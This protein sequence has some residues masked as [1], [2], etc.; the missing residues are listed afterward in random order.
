[1]KHFLIFF[2]ALF[3]IC[4]QA[5]RADASFETAIAPL[6]EEYN[7]SEDNFSIGYYNTLTGETFLYNGDEPMIAGSIYKLP[8][9]LTY[10]EMLD[11]GEIS[12]DDL[13]SGLTI[14]MAMQYVLE[15]SNNELAQSLQKNIGGSSVTRPQAAKYYGLEDGEELPDIYLTENAICARYALNMMTYIYENSDVYDICLSHLKNAQPDKYA[16]EYI[17]D[18]EI[19]Q[20]YGYFEGYFNDVAIVYTDSPFIMTV[21]TNNVSVLCLPELY[22]AA[23]EYSVSAN[24]VYNFNQYLIEIINFSRIL[25]LMVI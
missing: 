19:A 1:M 3:C 13:V 16:H 25:S 14:D 23:Y 18:C 12:G 5:V 21:F 17:T 6:V 4:S 20:K 7:L 15:F 11:A 8:I 2:C 9:C 24:A 22:K 10:E